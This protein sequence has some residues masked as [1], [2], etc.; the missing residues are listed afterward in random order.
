MKPKTW[1]KLQTVFM[2]GT[3]VAFYL[4]VPYLIKLVIWLG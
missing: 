3:L 4:L 1:R 2:L